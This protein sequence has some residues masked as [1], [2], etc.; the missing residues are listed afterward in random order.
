MYTKGLVSI[1]MPTYRRSDKLERAVKSVLGQSY[2]EIALFLVNDNIPGDEYSQEL[3]KRTEQFNADTRFTLL[4]QEKHINGAVAR[5]VG[6]KHSK[7]EFIAFLDDDDWWENDKIEKQVNAFSRL[8]KDYGVV[9]CRIKRYDNEKYLS[10]LPLYKSGV[11][12][13]DILMLVSDFAT[14]TLMFRR[15]ALDKT[16]YFDENL[17]RH[18]DLQILIQHTFKYK[19]YQLD[20]ALYCCDVSDTQNRP[21]VEKMITAKKNLYKSISSVLNSLS[22]SDRRAIYTINNAEVGYVMLRNGMYIRGFMKF[23]SLLWTPK[24]FCAELKKVYYK[25][26]GKIPK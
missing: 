22:N 26:N 14:G 9:S 13:K 21:N 10:T 24:A 4:H 16:G 15:E 2:K 7:G 6:I 17:L 19:L 12:Y 20:D 5:N 8:P 11:V 25:L 1:I 18:Q 3:V 23:I